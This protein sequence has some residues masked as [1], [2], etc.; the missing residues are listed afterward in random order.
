MAISSWSFPLKK[1]EDKGCG[2]MHL[3]L[4]FPPHFLVPLVFLRNLICSLENVFYILNNNAWRL[5]DIVCLH[6]F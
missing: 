4:V 2:D 6:F 5:I 3:W 1:M